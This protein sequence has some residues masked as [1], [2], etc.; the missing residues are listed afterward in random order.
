[1]AKLSNGQADRAAAGPGGLALTSVGVL[2]VLNGRADQSE[3]HLEA[4]TS[5]I[6]KADTSVVRLKGWFKPRVAAAITRNGHGYMATLLAGQMSINSQPVS[7]RYDLKDGDILHVSGLTL[8]F[9]LK[10]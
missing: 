1:M 2:R 5:L 3:Y 9:R 7:G 4:R 8:E 10:D 6:G